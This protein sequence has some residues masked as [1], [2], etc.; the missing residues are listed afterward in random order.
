MRQAL[1]SMAMGWFLILSGWENSTP[2]IVDEYASQ[3]DCQQARYSAG[4]SHF[5]MACIPS[6]EAVEAQK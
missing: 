4:I 2:I 1:A 5:K 6:A 3:E